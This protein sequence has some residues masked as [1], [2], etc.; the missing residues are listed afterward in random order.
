MN[1]QQIPGLSESLAKQ[2]KDL[3]QYSYDRLGENHPWPGYILP[4]GV[5]LSKSSY[6]K[7]FC[8]SYPTSVVCPYCDGAIGVP[9][10]D[11]Y[12][13]KSQFPLLTCSPWNLVPICRSCNDMIGGKG[14]QLA[15][16]PGPPR[17]TG[18]WLHPFYTPASKAARIR[19]LGAPGS[20]IPRLYSPDQIEQ[21]R[22]DN[23]TAL[24]DQTSLP[25]PKGT[26]S[27]RWTQVAAAY[28]ELLVRKVNEG[29]KNGRA[30][31]IVVR[32]NLEE[33]TEFRGRY[34]FMMIH[35]AVCEAVLDR[36]AEYAAEFDDSNP[37]AL[38]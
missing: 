14:D 27:E 11:H 25:R 16:D 19:L 34:P 1:L 30:M 13:C 22:L 17:S 32:E 33:S 37:P 18:M 21:T 3:F 31:E 7:A 20:P 10:L 8:S 28:F 6:K 9:E 2:V 35:A 23:H 12:Y 4:G 29:R 38:A 36:R 15:L 26:L 5:T 24:L